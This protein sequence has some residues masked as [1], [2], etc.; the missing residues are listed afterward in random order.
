MQVALKLLGMMTAIAVTPPCTKI[1]Q[2]TNYGS[3][4]WMQN[5]KVKKNL[6]PEKNGAAS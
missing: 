6:T 3:K 1:H 5:M 2:T 4:L